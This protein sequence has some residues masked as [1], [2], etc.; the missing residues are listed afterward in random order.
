M[1]CTLKNVKGF[2]FIWIVKFYQIKK[3]KG[4]VQRICAK[5]EN[6]GIFFAV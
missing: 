1:K 2:V 3:S 5:A 6:F 4:I